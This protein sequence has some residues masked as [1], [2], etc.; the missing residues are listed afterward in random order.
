MK[1]NF[2]PLFLPLFLFSF[3][4][5]CGSDGRNNKNISV[6]TLVLA[7]IGAGFCGIICYKIEDKTFPAPYRPSCP[8]SGSTYEQAMAHYHTL[9]PSSD[10]GSNISAVNSGDDIYSRVDT[11]DDSDR[12]LAGAGSLN[13][14][15]ND[16]MNNTEK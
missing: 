1:R 9:H 13:P 15:T 8:Y 14:K 3:S 7:S 16:E 2:L 5:C 10:D 11:H 6:T 12:G 4:S